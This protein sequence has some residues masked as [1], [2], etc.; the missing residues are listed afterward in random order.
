MKAE[1][2]TTIEPRRYE[3]YVW[4]S[5]EPK[6]RVLT[7]EECPFELENENEGTFII[8]AQLC[9]TK[10]Q[11]SY[12]VKHIG[13][14]HVIMRYEFTDGDFNCGS[15][16]QKS[17]VAHRINKDPE[18]APEKAI[19]TL[20]FLQCWEPKEDPACLGMPVLHPTHLVFTGFT[21]AKTQE[22]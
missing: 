2:V 14:E 19:K 10:G 4:M 17:F 11:V 8:E 12:S 7:T 16:T 9:D 21:N 5:N 3:G 6:P 13:G 15:I 1:K 22:K 20:Y 18:M